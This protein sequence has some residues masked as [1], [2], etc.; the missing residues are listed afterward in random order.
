V[1]GLLAELHEI[2]APGSHRCRAA[3]SRHRRHVS[4][5]LVYSTIFRPLVN[6]TCRAATSL[7]DL[8]W[9]RAGFRTRPSF[10]RWSSVVDTVLLSVGCPS[11]ASAAVTSS[12][13]VER[14]AVRRICTMASVRARPS[15]PPC[16]WTPDTNA[17]RSASK[18]CS[19]DG[20]RDDH[21]LLLDRVINVC[22]GVFEQQTQ[23]DTYHYQE[24]IGIAGEAGVSSVS[25]PMLV[26]S[27]QNPWRNPRAQARTPRLRSS[28]DRATVS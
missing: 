9:P 3:R 11:S 18:P 28:V 15:T 16:G 20:R 24:L 27:R 7:G 21:P 5:K 26:K 4:A 1:L 10:L 22:N 12:G 13:L 19:R 6:G 2:R 14:P 8:Y 23:E 25:R 17:A